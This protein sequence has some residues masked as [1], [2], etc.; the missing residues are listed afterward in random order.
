MADR[1]S[2]SLDFPNLKGVA[3]I[4]GRGAVSVSGPRRASTPLIRGQRSHRQGVDRALHLL[5]KNPVDQALGL[6]DSSR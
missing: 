6:Y 4:L 5:G 2:K 3:A 1:I